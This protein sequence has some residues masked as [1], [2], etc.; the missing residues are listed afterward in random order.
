MLRLT[1]MAALLALAPSLAAAEPCADRAEFL[2]ILASGFDEV[3]VATGLTADGRV[4]EVSASGNGSWT[5]IVTMP[6]GQTCGVLAGKAWSATSEH[7]QIAEDVASYMTALLALAPSFAEAE[8]C[9]G[10]AEFLEILANGYD[11]VP[12]AMG[13]T[14]DGRV[15]E[16]YASGNGSWTII[17]TMS[18]GRTCGILAGEGWSGTQ[19]IGDDVAS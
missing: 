11:E 17:V 19:R 9:A 12:V 2:E 16:V 10:R 7:Q 6:S 13:L 5:I 1:L 18:A 3:P 8:L 15:V 4:V 14:A